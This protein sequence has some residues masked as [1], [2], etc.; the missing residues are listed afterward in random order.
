ME[1]IHFLTRNFNLIYYSKYFKD[2][3]NKYVYF[4]EKNCYKLNLIKKEDFKKYITELKKYN[5]IYNNNKLYYYYLFIKE[6]IISYFKKNFLNDIL[7]ISKKTF[8]FYIIDN[9]G[10]K[11]IIKIKFLTY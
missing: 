4:Y 8:I 1:N 11:D 3:Q 7:D 2:V 9:I 6:I 5:E 10:I